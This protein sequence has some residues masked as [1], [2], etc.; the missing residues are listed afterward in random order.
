MYKPIR[1]AELVKG[2][3]TIKQGEIFTLAFQLFGND[4][5]I[6]TLSNEIVTVKIANTTGVIH[7]TDAT[8]IGDQ[9]EFT[10]SENIGYGKM[11][12]EIK[13]TSGE[14]LLHKYPADGWIELNITKSLDDLGVGGLDTVT[15]DEMFAEIAIIDGVAANALTVSQSADGK[16]DNAVLVANEAKAES[17]NALTKS[18]NAETIAIASDVKSTNAERLATQALSVSSSANEKSTNAE[19][20]A[21]ETKARADLIIGQTGDSN[22]EI[23]DSRLGADLIARPTSGTLIREIHSQQLESAKQTTTL[24]HGTSIIESSQPSPLDV[25]FNGGTLVNLLGRIGNFEKDSNS[26]GSADDFTKA[27]SG[28][29]ATLETTNVKYGTK[30]QKIAS[31]V[32]DTLG[33]R[34]LRKDLLNFKTGKYYIALVDVVTDGATLAK[35]RTYYNGETF[36]GIEVGRAASGLLY[37]KFSPTSESVA[38]GK[39]D[40]VNNKELGGV[41][42]VQFDG[43]RIYEIDLATYDKIGVSLLEA[44][45]EKM[46]PYVDSVQHVKN[47][48]VTVEGDNLIPPFTEWDLHANAKV[49]SPYEL[50]LNATASTQNSAYMVPVLPSE[51]YNLK[52]EMSS[53]G[54]NGIL[55]YDFNKAFISTFGGGYSATQER[56]FTSP[57]NA[58]YADVRL[59]NNTTSTGKFTFTQPILTL[60][61]VAKPFVPRNPSYLYADVKLGAIGKAKDILY[62][63]GGSHFVRKAIEKDVVLDGSLGWAYAVDYV[64]FKRID[65]AAIAISTTLNYKT[66]ITKY[67]GVPKSGLSTTNELPNSGDNHLLGNT[68]TLYITLLDTDT[69]WGETYPPLSTETKAYFRGWKMNNG[70]YGVN[71]DGTG[72][73]TW[74]PIGDTSNTRSVTVVPT[75][76]SPTQLDGTIQPF[77]LSYVLVT[78]Q[79]VNVSDKVEGHLSIQG[80]AQIAISEGVIVREVA[81]PVYNSGDGHYYVNNKAVVGSKFT[82]RANYI[83]KMNKNGVTDNKWVI[84][85]HTNGYGNQFAKIPIADFDAAATYT[86]TYEVMDKYGFTTNIQ[87]VKAYY[88]SSLKSA[89]KSVVS[90]QSDIETDQSILERQML[91]VFIRLEAGGL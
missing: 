84:M 60:G 78:P 54:H 10:V 63:Q 16:A 11:D 87:E 36:T 53:G 9:I 64:G 58:Y 77:I 18:N 12:V 82:Q 29:I 71:Y 19:T 88:D 79:I 20:L 57:S 56:A 50:E 85:S 44:D 25:E 24:S 73:K 1:R 83:L 5:K 86:V 23:V 91:D 35:L 42:W 27:L 66:V 2:G 51:N 37:L 75:S 90:K 15:S 52:V 30:A 47:P 41:G 62:G 70:V 22:T 13:V 17:G 43:L 33:I 74:I 59:N 68:G 31:T 67:D 38:N 81:N 3:F 34:Y 46:F 55:F 89:F 69:G 49:I 61:N 45:I 80:N 65:V 21:T 4:N 6:I 14:T 39:I 26:D 32:N 40:V 72:T 8:I 7:Q 48:V 28:G 76:E